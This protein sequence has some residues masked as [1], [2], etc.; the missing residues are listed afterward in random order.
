ML[1]HTFYS[2]EKEDTY[3]KVFHQMEAELLDYWTRNIGLL[4]RNIG[5]LDYCNNHPK[6]QGYVR[7]KL[8]TI[9][10]TSEAM[11][12]SSVDLSMFKYIATVW[13]KH[14]KHIS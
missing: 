10:T 3:L 6:E 14:L 1:V 11:L 2:H 7:R 8:Y 13:N 12:S 5:V 9:L 4:T